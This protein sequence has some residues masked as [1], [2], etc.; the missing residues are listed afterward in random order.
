VWSN[1]V[2]LNNFLSPAPRCPAPETVTLEGGGQKHQISK[3]WFGGERG[4]NRVRVANIRAV[5][6]ITSL[7][8]PLDAQLPKQW[9]WRGGQKHQ[10]SKQWFLGGG[11][12]RNRVRV[13]NIRAVFCGHY[14]LWHPRWL[15]YSVG[16]PAKSMYLP[17]SRPR[18]PHSTW[19]PKPHTHPRGQA[20]CEPTTPRPKRLKTLWCARPHIRITG[21][22]NRTDCPFEMLAEVQAKSAPHS[23]YG[24]E[25]VSTSQ[26]A[27]WTAT[28]GNHFAGCK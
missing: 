24:R 27:A 3:Q 5:F 17:V 15:R 23:F 22:F 21:M 16:L 26:P 28:L 14:R 9:L 6:W 11:R 4:R 19:T 7:P 20:G 1:S 13:A 25:L 18:H 2:R 12:G 10:I 8:P